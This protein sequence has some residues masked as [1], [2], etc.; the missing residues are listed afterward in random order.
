M[1]SENESLMENCTERQNKL[2]GQRFLLKAIALV[3]RN[4]FGKYMRCTPS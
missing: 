4:I 1:G 3:D 2:K